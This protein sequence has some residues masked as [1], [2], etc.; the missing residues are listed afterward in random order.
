MS[1]A[2]INFILPNHELKVKNYGKILIKNYMV[3]KYF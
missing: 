3:I 1:M 2:F